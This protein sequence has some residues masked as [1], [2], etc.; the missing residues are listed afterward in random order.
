[1]MMTMTHCLHLSLGNHSNKS[2]VDKHSIYVDKFTRLFY[3]LTQLVQAA[4]YGR[5]CWL[6]RWWLLSVPR[7]LLASKKLKSSSVIWFEV[8]HLTNSCRCLTFPVALPCLLC[9]RLAPPSSAIYYEQT[10][11]FPTYPFTS[12]TTQS[13]PP[14]L[15]PQPC[16]HLWRDVGDV[17]A[18][19][20]NI[21]LKLLFKIYLL[22]DLMKFL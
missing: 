2:K 3:L 17:T 14:K 1:M 6:C 19:Y 7:V 15:A 12:H 10:I 22:F 11:Q 9:T 20:S 18:C 21:F 8:S 5:W 13:H 4:N 16:L